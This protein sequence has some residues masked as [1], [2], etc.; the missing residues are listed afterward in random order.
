[1]LNVSRS[2]ARRLGLWIGL[3][4]A[5]QLSAWITLA[6]AADP[7]TPKIILDAWQRRANKLRSFDFE[8]DLE[9]SM[10]AAGVAG[11]VNLAAQ[12]IAVQENEADPVPKTLKSSL[13]FLMSDNK[14]AMSLETEIWDTSAG[15]KSSTAQV[16]KMVFNGRENRELNSRGEMH[17][18][19]ITSGAQPSARMV[20]NLYFN[21]IWLSTNPMAYLDE[22][23]AFQSREMTIV[24]AHKKC[25]DVE[26][27]E[28]RI[29]RNGNANVAGLI[30]VDPARDYIPIRFRKRQTWE[31]T[32]SWPLRTSPNVPSAGV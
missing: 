2:G 26:C 10:P 21:A 18:G 11:R 8:C 13:S 19:T 6:G 1:M 20:T 25:G 23:L 30:Y 22:Y 7:V 9:R 27:I 5:S 32:T 3:A 31:R 17:T 4:I 12:P 29:P 15:T 14:Y 24:D 28:L 16:L